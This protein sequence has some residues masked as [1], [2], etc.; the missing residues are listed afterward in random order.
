MQKFI[1]T[2]GK[3]LRGELALQGSKN[4]SLPIMAAALLCCGECTL[5]S[6][7]KLTDVYAASRILNCVGCRC[8]FSDNTAVIDSTFVDR[9]H[10][11]EEL[12]REMRS[13]IIFM[14]AMLGRA[15]ECTVSV[16]GGCELG[17]RPID[18]HLAALRKMGVDITESGGSIICR[19][20]LGRAK[21]AKISLAFPSVGATEN[22]ILCAVTAD[23]E[24]VIN[25]AAREPEI[26][27]L[28]GFLRCCGADIMG[29]G[30]SRIVIKG[31]KQL[32]GCE[33]TIMPDRI[34]AATYLSMVAATRGE[35]ILT[36]ACVPETE[37]F[38]SVLEQTGC[39][40]YTSENK[41]YLRSGTRL[42]A[43][44]ERIRTMPHPGFPTDAQAV[45][46]AAL[47]VADGTSIFEENIFDC[48]YRHT[49]ALIKMGA[50]IQVLGKVA[51]V[52]GVEKLRGANVQAT[53]LR[54]GAAMIIAAL[55][56][57]GTSEIGRI[58]HIDRGY[59]KIEEAV[60]L[61]GGDM[62]R[63]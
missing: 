53:D 4:S 43:V 25:N 1:I 37:P 31:K 9:T 7:P 24:T 5:H 18:M 12:M 49:D 60:R 40:I 50:D 23:G 57:T 35:L 46:M 22:V 59:E 20:A 36:N 34:A 52:K 51:V 56:G 32:H 28:C 26:C 44:R 30:E 47:A 38:L 2:G 17:P 61:L 27:D 11:S 15:G 41:I 6:C 42:K 21:G 33:Y 13:S 10:I 8:T 29:D 58:C 55:C 14:G 16:P 19:A 54:G 3:S 39:S 63:V 45:L 48:R 62:R